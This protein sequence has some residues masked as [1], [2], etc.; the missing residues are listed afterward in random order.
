MFSWSVPLVSCFVERQVWVLVCLF[1]EAFIL[2][3]LTVGTW[4]ELYFIMAHVSDCSCLFNYLSLY[5]FKTVKAIEQFG[6]VVEE[7]L[8]KHGKKIIGEFLLLCK[9]F[10]K[11]FV[12]YNPA[13]LQMS[14]LFW[15]GWLTV[16]L[17]FMPWWWFCPGNLCR[18]EMIA[19]H[20]VLHVTIYLV[21]KRASYT[22]IP[23]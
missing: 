7:L 11:P 21:S 10:F 6:S 2:S 14:S 20:T 1:K 12:R 16:P 9:H 13:S 17:T 4:Y 19:P 15:R 3:W 5:P 23:L 8:I 18:T 22:V